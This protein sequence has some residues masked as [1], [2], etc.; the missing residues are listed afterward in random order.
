[1]SRG[2]IARAN[3]RYPET[4]RK[5]ARYGRTVRVRRAQGLP[6][7][8]LSGA[9]GRNK[10]IS[11]NRYRIALAIA[12]M[13]LALMIVGIGVFTVS[14]AA[15][16]GGTL[17][18]YRDLNE[19]LPA[20]AEVASESFETSRI[21]DRNGN[22]L[23]EVD[24][25]NTGWRTFVPLDEVSPIAIQ[26]TVAAEDATFWSHYGVEPLAIVRGALI[27]V[28][29]EGSS[30]GSTITQQ[31]ARGLYPEKVGTDISISRKIREA[32]A[33]VA[34]D[35]EYSK[36]DILSMY[37]NLIY[38]GQRS[39]GIEAAAQTF[40]DK[41]A[42][43]LNL[44]E[45]SMLAG[46]PQ[47]PSA[48]DP[49]VNY[50]AAKERQRYV[51]DQ[52][53]EYRYITRTE[54]E[55]AFNVLLKP[56]RRSNAIQ[57][58]PH[59]TNYVKDY[60]GETYGENALYEGGLQITTS[61]DIELQDRAEEI[62]NEQIQSNLLA[63]G[64]NNAAMVIM[65]P[66]SGEILAMVG[67]A[68]F[69]D[70]VIG[71]QNNYAV[72]PLQPGSSIKPVVY[73]KA[74]EDGWNP[75]TVIFDTT[76]SEPTA[77]GPYEPRNYTGQFFGAV[78]VRTALA[79]S[80]NIPAVKT[81]SY[82]GVDAMMELGR[83][84]GLRDSFAGQASDYGYGTSLALGAGEVTLLEHTNVYATLAN[85]GAYVPA[86]P[87]LKITDSQD[88]VLYEIEEDPHVTDPDQALRA[89]YAY[90]ITSILTDNEE[91]AMI[92]TEENLFASTEDALGRPTAAKSGT[93]DNWK[94]IW[95]MGYTTDVAIGVWTGQTT[96]GGDRQQQLPELD[97]I[98]G[99]GPIWQEMMIEV[100]EDAEWSEYLR[101]PNGQA[102]PEAFPRPDGIYEGE[103][104]VAT[105]GRPTGGSSS[106]DE[107]LVRGAGPSLDCNQIS[108]YHAQELEKALAD[109]RTNG[110]QYTGSGP[111]SIYRYAEAVGQSNNVP[112]SFN[113]D[114]DDDDEEFFSE[115]DD[116]SGDDGFSGND[117]DSSPD[118]VPRD[119]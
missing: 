16:V 18:A 9:G 38:Y 88:N 118:I 27:I 26:A 20:A 58:A 90:Q 86:N 49:T 14:S 25:P 99:A 67:S 92:F 96:Q 115:E 10:E 52:M 24:N 7:N 44:A 64:R 83:R 89:E 63:Y 81:A 39:Y 68:N 8:L 1:M 29:G 93:T 11:T 5:A 105:G 50:E 78:S 4:R 2:R 65:V 119:D 54:A 34:I 48:Y 3:R 100:H 109:V 114:D 57:H 62:I 101:G 72:S 113:D 94:D 15:A 73:A 56:Q 32:M 85:N 36:Q 97:G 28:G 40:F 74:F 111:D 76:Y 110:G 91:R 19:S 77:Q 71:G 51:L 13:S 80:L 82:T 37:L 104:C 59:F 60:I 95:T 112:R 53:V 23:Q 116:F 35:N 41:H 31:L 21:Y 69:D 43:E 42:S 75:G 70:P 79:N 6:P 47:L 33:A 55:E 17:N 61:I 45:A 117:D 12:L 22:L 30:G 46:L 106:R 108:S 103:V 84:M 87:I 107:L 98:Q 102:V 66:W